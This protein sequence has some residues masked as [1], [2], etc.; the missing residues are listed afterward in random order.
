MDIEPVKFNQHSSCVNS[1]RNKRTPQTN[2]ERTLH[3]PGRI[4]I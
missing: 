1:K 3:D 2:S 4:K